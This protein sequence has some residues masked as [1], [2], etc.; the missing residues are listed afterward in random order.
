MAVDAFSCNQLEVTQT[1]T[2]QDHSNN[3]CSC[4]NTGHWWAQTL[5]PP[6][7]FQNQFISALLLSL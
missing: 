1:G 4:M 3:H 2:D 6:K 5:H 7:S